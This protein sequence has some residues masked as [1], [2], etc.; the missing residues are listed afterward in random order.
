MVPIEQLKAIHK[1]DEAT[2]WAILL[3]DK[4]D[5]ERLVLF[6]PEKEEVNAINRGI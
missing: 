5:E 1:L 3:E 6:Y 2:L 4:S